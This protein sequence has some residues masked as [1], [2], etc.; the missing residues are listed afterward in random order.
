MATPTIAWLY[1]E[2]LI[3]YTHTH[4]RQIIPLYYWG[5]VRIGC[6]FFVLFFL[7]ILSLPE[8]SRVRKGGGDLGKNMWPFFTHRALKSIERIVLAYNTVLFSQERKTSFFCFQLGIFWSA[9]GSFSLFSVYGYRALSV[10][11]MTR[12]SHFRFSSETTTAKREEMNM[13]VPY[14]ELTNIRGVSARVHDSLSSN[15]GSTAQRRLD[16]SSSPFKGVALRV[17]L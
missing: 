12:V 2:R 4:R 17:L 1:R 7:L 11:H 9:R 15:A 6:F 3:R 8:L 16:N 14:K 10:K 5:G 13:H